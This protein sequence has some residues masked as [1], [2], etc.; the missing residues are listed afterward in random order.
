M[1][2]DYKP[3]GEVEGYQHQLAVN[4]METVSVLRKDPTGMLTKLIKPNLYY[5]GLLIKTI[6]L[7]SNS[8]NYTSFLM[9]IR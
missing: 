3:E 7:Q 5:T 9:P 8:Q 4:A 1:L 6:I 2:A